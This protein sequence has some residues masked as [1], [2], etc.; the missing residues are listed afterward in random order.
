[1]RNKPSVNIVAMPTFLK[2]LKRLSK[3]YSGIANDLKVL[4]NRLEVG[5]TPGDQIQGIGYT[6]YKARLR[7]RDASRGKSGG[8][9]VIYYL[10]TEEKLL[11]VYIYSKTERV[12]ISADEIRRMIEEYESS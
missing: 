9:R 4:T 1:M 6:V 5:E 11:L 3:K 10:K 8:F 12:D 7:N 2:A